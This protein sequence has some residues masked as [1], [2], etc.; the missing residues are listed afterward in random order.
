MSNV[1]TIDWLLQH[2]FSELR[3][4]LLFSNYQH[5]ISIKHNQKTIQ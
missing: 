3:M 1:L 2:H 4:C 5:P